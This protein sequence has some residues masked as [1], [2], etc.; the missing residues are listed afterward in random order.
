[1]KN[2]YIS[3]K[4]EDKILQK[5]ARYFFADLMQMNVLADIFYSICA[6]KDDSANNLS[7]YYAVGLVPENNDLA[8]DFFSDLDHFEVVEDLSHFKVLERKCAFQDLILTTTNQWKARI[9]R[10]LIAFEEQNFQLIA[11]LLY[12]SLTLDEFN[13]LPVAFLHLSKKYQPRMF[14]THELVCIILERDPTNLLKLPELQGIHVTKYFERETNK[15]PGI[16]VHAGEKPLLLEVLVEQ[17]VHPD[18]IT[19]LGNAKPPISIKNK[20]FKPMKDVIKF[21]MPEI[22]QLEIVKDVKID[23]EVKL[24]LY[25]DA[26]PEVKAD[27]DYVAFSNKILMSHFDELQNAIGFTN[28]EKTTTLPLKF[29]GFKIRTHRDI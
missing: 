26:V 6:K 17:L 12:K 16:F 25:L 27:Y 15:F 11:D 5:L 21:E 2:R 24:Q 8:L 28:A 20:Q 13:S 3:F 4:L 14:D 29:F 18:E 10:T 19:F 22:Q 7:D 1:M 9:E 23:I